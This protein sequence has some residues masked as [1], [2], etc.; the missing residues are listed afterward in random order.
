MTVLK[1]QAKAKPK[2][3]LSV[4][5][6]IYDDGI[7]DSVVSGAYTTQQRKALISAIRA[8]KEQLLSRSTTR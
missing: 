7:I 4:A 3:R 8:A 1:F 5:I 2:D 6:T